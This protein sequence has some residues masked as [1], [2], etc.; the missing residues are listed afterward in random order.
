V[1]K[2]VK[3]YAQA[4]GSA[5]PIDGIL[6]LKIQNTAVLLY[7]TVGSMDPTNGILDAAMPKTSV[8]LNE[9]DSSKDLMNGIPRLAMCENV[10]FQELHFG[11]PSI[12]VS[13]GQWY[14]QCVGLPKIIILQ[15]PAVLLV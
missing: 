2:L 10:Y 9:T 7:E 8:L 13:T 14:P 15:R 5:D 11:R 12:T 6:H 1:I 4:V 3:L